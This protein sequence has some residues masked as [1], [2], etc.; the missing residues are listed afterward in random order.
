MSSDAPA[1]PL[2]HACIAC[3]LPVQSGDGPGGLAWHDCE[4]V[5]EL[6]ASSLPPPPPPPPG[7]SEL[8]NRITQSISSRV[9][10]FNAR[11]LAD[12][13]DALA[14]LRATENARGETASG[15]SQALRDYV[16]KRKAAAQAG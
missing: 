11:E 3:G 12:V 16:A 1:V 8:L 15:P 14:K 4:W 13:L 9:D 5:V 2:L 7:E 6:K 10:K